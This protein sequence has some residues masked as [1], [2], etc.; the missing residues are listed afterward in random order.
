VN[1][2]PLCFLVEA[3][4]PVYLDDDGN[5]LWWSNEGGWSTLDQAIVF[6]PHEAAT[7]NLPMGGQW[8]P[9]Y[10]KENLT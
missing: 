1:D 5:P 8:V 9:M 4:H 3:V 6:T 10:R 2:T 7:L